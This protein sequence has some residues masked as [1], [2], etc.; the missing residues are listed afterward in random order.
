MSVDNKLLDE[1]EAAAKELIATCW[2]HES[3]CNSCTLQSNI[4]ALVSHIYELRAA[5]Q[6]YIENDGDD[7]DDEITQQAR[8]ALS[9]TK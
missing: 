5:L 7:F 2:W 4:L 8:A 6:R 1:M 9:G 3:P